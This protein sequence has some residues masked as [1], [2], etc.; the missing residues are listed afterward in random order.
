MRAAIAGAVDDK[1]AGQLA[2][3]ATEPI[4][5]EPTES[6]AHR[7]FLRLQEFDLARRIDSLRKDLQPRNP[8][9]DPQYDEMFAQLSKLEGE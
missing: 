6:Y 3:L 5:G 2:A 8:M 7:V 9:K 1:V 4:E